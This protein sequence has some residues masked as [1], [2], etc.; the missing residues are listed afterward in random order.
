[1]Q[2]GAT[3]AWFPVVRSALAIKEAA[4]PIGVALS[5]CNPKQ[6]EK[7]DDLGKLKALV[8]MGMFPSLE[9]FSVDDVWNAILKQRGEIETED[10]DLRWPEWLA[11]HDLP[12]RRATR[13]SCSFNQAKRQQGSR[14]RTPRRPRS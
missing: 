10:I 8:D 3:N 1:M 12:R 7:V 6:I 11:F 4:T 13:A 9:P 5:A 2:R 14:S